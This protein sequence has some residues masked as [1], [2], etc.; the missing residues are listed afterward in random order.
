MR[1]ITAI[2]KFTPVHWLY[3]LCNIDPQKIR[4]CDKL[5]KEIDKISNLPIN[6]DIG[7]NEFNRLNTGH[8]HAKLY[9]TSKEDHFNPKTTG[10]DTTRILRNVSLNLVFLAKKNLSNFKQGKR[11]PRKL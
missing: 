11:H 5:K 4:R 10:N 3:V 6:D 1:N 9:K 8:P 7:N 2:I